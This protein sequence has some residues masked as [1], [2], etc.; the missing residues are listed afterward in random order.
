M[1]QTSI[2]DLNGPF[3]H[4][5]GQATFYNSLIVLGPFDPELLKLRSGNVL[6]VNL[7]EQ[8]KHRDQCGHAQIKLLKGITQLMAVK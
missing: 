5:Q 4:N 6:D 7:L 1:R 3:K 8:K 2:S